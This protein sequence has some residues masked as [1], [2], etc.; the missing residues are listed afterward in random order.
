[1]QPITII[2]K[3]GVRKGLKA[4]SWYFWKRKVMRNLPSDA[5][6]RS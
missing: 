1:M 2:I 4:L 6:Y 5:K 3:T